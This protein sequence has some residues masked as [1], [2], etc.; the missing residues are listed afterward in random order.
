M[1]CFSLETI[2]H[3]STSTTPMFYV[4]YS[5]TTFFEFKSCLVVLFRTCPKVFCQDC[6]TKASLENGTT[7][8]WNL[9]LWKHS[10]LVATFFYAKG[11]SGIDCSSTRALSYLMHHVILFYKLKFLMVH[12]CIFITDDFMDSKAPVWLYIL[13]VL[14]KKHSIKHM[15]THLR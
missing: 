11:N 13:N 4:Y 2:G 10:L 7:F 9:K 6:H 1:W 12:Q 14:F 8:F 15:P 5:T 3:S